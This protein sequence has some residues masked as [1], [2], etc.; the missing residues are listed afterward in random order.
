MQEICFSLQYR[1]SVI[2]SIWF[3][4]GTGKLVFFTT[5]KTVNGGY[6]SQVSLQLE[7]EEGLIFLD[8]QAMG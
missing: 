3:V 4:P 2:K 1:R 6:I 8:V 5:A 7:C